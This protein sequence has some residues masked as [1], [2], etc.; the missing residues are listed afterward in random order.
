MVKPV[1]YAAMNERTCS[2]CGLTK[3]VAEFNRY[4]DASAPIAGWR[5]HSWCRDCANAR[6]RIYGT[7][8][9][10]RRNERLREWRAANPEAARR[11]DRRA[12]L[13]RKYGLTEADLD[14]MKNEAAN[15]CALCDREVKLVIDHDH[16]TG[17]V[18]GLLCGQCNTLLGWLERDGVRGRVDSYLA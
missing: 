2:K 16:S 10:S 11:K 18:R 5:Y 17:R 6:S 4:V 9:R 1:D 3:P 12:R 7:Q 8:N 13:K 14:A 15:K